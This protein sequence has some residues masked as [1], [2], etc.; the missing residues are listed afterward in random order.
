MFEQAAITGDTLHKLSH[1][2]QSATGIRESAVLA[3][4]SR[5]EVYADVETR[6]QSVEAI[7]DVLV[8]HCDIAPGRLVPYLYE[9]ADDNALQHLFKVASGL[10]SMVIGEDQIVGQLR[11]AFQLA[12][13]RRTVGRSLH[14]IM[15]R[16]LRVGK[17]ARS[18]T[19]VNSAGASL[20]TVGLDIVGPLAGKHALVVGAGSMGT[21]TAKTLAARGIAAVTVTNRTLE[22][23]E[24]LA[25]K[26]PVP[27]TAIPL[28]AVPEVLPD[29]DLVVSCLGTGEY[30][31]TAD[32]VRGPVV[33][34]DLAAPRSIDPRTALHLDVTLVSLD[35]LADW[36]HATEAD[37]EG[38]MRII[39]EE[40]TDYRAKRRAEAV[41]PTV[42]ALRHKAA[43]V[44]DRELARLATRAPGLDKQE[45]DAVAQTVRR[46]VNKIL[47]APTVRVQEL[48]AAPGG[49]RYV[50]MLADLFDLAPAAPEADAPDPA[51]LEPDTPGANTPEPAAPEAD[52]P[53]PPEPAAHGGEGDTP[54]LSNRPGPI[55]HRTAGAAET[56]HP[57]TA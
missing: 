40:A 49:E 25:E 42:T 43:S 17:R 50:D 14:D 36:H 41:A 11:N 6:A 32:M 52:A 33:L 16:A 26:L 27:A 57:A 22:R 7:T 29:A 2:V 28:A 15:Q 9:F 45:N 21:L 20:V 37:V 55:A 12:Q 34:L 46:V 1:D 38:V 35:D 56:D 44:I 5:V 10:D 39:A 18:E 51:A 19:D 23:A 4:C 24:R 31:I 8:R 53:H 3:T 47:H 30:V 13:E 54:Q 48:A